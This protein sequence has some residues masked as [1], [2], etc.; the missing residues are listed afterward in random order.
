VRNTRQHESLI[1]GCGNGP[2][3]VSGPFRVVGS[4]HYGLDSNH[5]GIACES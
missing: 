1:S 4:D 2:S 3:Y 5:D